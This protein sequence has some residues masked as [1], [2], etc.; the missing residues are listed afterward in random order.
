MSKG[1]GIVV[2][3]AAVAL[4][5]S[6]KAVES[7]PVGD[8]RSFCMRILDATVNRAYACEGGSREAYSAAIRTLD[9]CNAVA[10]IIEASHVSFDVDAATACVQDFVGLDCW[11]NANASPNCRKVFIGT[12]A[13]EGVCYPSLPMGAQE[14]APGTICSTTLQGCTGR[15]VPGE[16]AP[17]PVSTGKACT[18]IADCV[19]DEG[20]LTCADANGPIVTGTGT[21]QPP[22]AGGPCH[23]DSDC[24]SEVCAGFTGTA[25]GTCQ[26]P[27][28]VGD[29]CTPAMGECGPG[30]YCGSAN[31]CVQLPTLGQ[32]CAGDHGAAD[33]CLGGICD[34][35]GLC[36]P[37]A[38]KGEACQTGLTSDSCGLGV[39]RCDA[40]TLTCT[41][42]CMP[43]NGCGAPGQIC[44]AGG[45]CNAGA[46]CNAGMCS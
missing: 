28:H 11:Q 15:C 2:G 12:V 36:I 13:L 24:R 34:M 23:Y 32:P 44:C 3:F 17:H 1:I 43:G 10:P 6:S 14:C 5:C 8:V 26:A 33:E 45:L 18:S 31:T 7:G 16:I 39:N 22:A 46:A 30:T 20:S 4:G 19:G 27:K 29:A 41:P 25:P 42:T 9:F 37:F 21:C 35:T 38:K 40:T